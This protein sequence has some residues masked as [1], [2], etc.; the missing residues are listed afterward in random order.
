[1]HKSIQTILNRYTIGGTDKGEFDITHEDAATPEEALQQAKTRF[2]GTSFQ[3]EE[4]L[5]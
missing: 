1:M 3:P 4:V 5:E 2:R